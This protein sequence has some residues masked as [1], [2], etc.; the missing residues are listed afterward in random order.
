M[1]S[2]G[3]ETDSLAQAVVQSSIDGL[4]VMDRDTRYVLW[5]RTMELF[6]GKKAAE[7]LGQKAFEIFP[8]LRELGLDKAFHRVL[9]GESVTTEGAPYVGPDGVRR[10]F[11]RLYVP[12]RSGGDA[13]TGVL[14]I[15]RD[16]T[17]RYAAQ[18]ELRTSEAKLRMTAEGTGTGLWSWDPTDDRITWD[19]TM[20]TLCGL[21]PGAVP[22]DLET[23]LT[24][25][26]PDERARASERI[27]RGLQGGSWS[28]EFRILRPDGTTR[29]VLSKARVQ[30]ADGRPLVL[31]TATDVTDRKEHDERLRAAQRLEAI[32]GLTAGI[33][34]NFNNM[35]MGLV[36]NLELAVEQASPALAPLLADAKQAAERAADVVRQLMTYAGRNRP[37]DRTAQPITPV[38]E[39]TAAFCRTTF[40]RRITLDVRCDGAALASFDATQLEQALLNLL[41]NARDAV[42]APGVAAPA[43]AV[44][45]DLVPRGAPELDGRAGRWLAI[46]VTDNGVG[47][48]AATAQRAFEPFFTTKGVG[49][50][51]GLGLATTLG[52]VREH[53]GFIACR[54]APGKGATFTIHLPAAT[55]EEARR[56][57]ERTMA[58][59]VAAPA[60]GTVM[61][62]DD[63]PAVRRVICRLLEDDGFSVRAAGSGTEALGILADASVAATVSVI[64]LD[65]SMPGLSGPETRARLRQVVP[66]ARVAYLT[67]YAYQTADG[68]EVVQKPVTADVLLS[69]VQRLLAT[70]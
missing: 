48:D 30:R 29:W 13:V 55:A 24:V 43:I 40:D 12:L 33:A 59:A 65:V 28:D 70:G 20:R 60:S 68:D 52:I 37:V 41:I 58:A 1:P 11:D 36:P 50:G 10:I 7:V 18:D 5:N 56:D 31:G 4:A 6:S 17:A 45:V 25:L 62:I 57:S 69:V 47:M 67:G 49:R 34:H 39:R 19:D 27:R 9:A 3:A 15:V 61:V 51:T 32:G 54:S 2:P 42:D 44:S 63:E 53:L 46:R 8:F 16:A 21:E 23:Y 66:N 22:H 64:L 14:A 26:H 38:I 35:L